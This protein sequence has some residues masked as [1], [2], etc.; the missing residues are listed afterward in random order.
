MPSTR[1][2]SLGQIVDTLTGEVIKEAQQ[3]GEI[4][5]G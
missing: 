2:N 1:R 5:E 4:V 3:D